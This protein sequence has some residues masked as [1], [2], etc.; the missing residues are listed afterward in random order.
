[1]TSA[2]DITS[3]L[4]SRH[5]AAGR[6]SSHM[7]RLPI[8]VALALIVVGCNG[9]TVDRHAMEKDAEAI[10]SLACEGALLANEIAYRAS[11][12]QFSRVHAGDLRTKASNFADALS[13]R[14]TVPRIEKQVRELAAK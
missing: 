7:H 2:A 4:G 1:M 9:G 3:C 13:V 11:T 5:V 14:P 10:D 8:L 12:P 6:R